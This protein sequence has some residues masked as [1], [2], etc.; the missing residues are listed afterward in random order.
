MLSLSTMGI[1]AA[2]FLAA[3]A[4]TQ[5]AS[6]QSVTGN[7]SSTGV[8]YGTNVPG[9]GA[10]ATQTVN[11]A[12]GDSSYS[13]TPNGPDANGS[14]LDAAYGTV[15]NGYLYL[16]FA[17]NFENN[18]NPVNIFIDD[19]RAGGQNTLNAPG[20]AGNMTTMNGSV[21]SPGFNA[22][23]AFEINDYQGTAYIDQFNLLPSG[24]G[25]FVGSVPLSAGVGASQSVN[26]S[27][28]KLGLNNSNT[29]GVTGD[30]TG[31]AA[32]AAN[33]QAVS[34]GM[35]L[36]VPLSLLGN[37]TGNIKVMADINGGGDSYLSNQFLPGLTPAPQGNVGA[38]GGAFSGASSGQFNLS[39]LSNFWFTVQ[40]VVVPDGIWLP[41]GDGSWDGSTT[42]NWSN[43]HIPNAAGASA[44]FSS[45]TA[46]A[47]VT[48][49]GNRTVGSMTIDDSNSYTFTPGAS[50]QLTLDN[51]GSA[52]TASITDV[53]G[54][55]TISVPLSLTS[56]V[57]IN[58]LSNGSNLT[59]SGNIT[60]AGAVSISSLGH[61]GILNSD[62]DVILS[63]NNNYLG[64]TTVN[65]GTLKLGSSTALP[66]NTSL[67]LVSSDAPAGAL[68]LNGFN[69][70]I[71]SIAGGNGGGGGAG[72]TQILNSSATAGTATLTY[73]GSNLSPNTF[74]GN[75]KDS[76]GT[77]GNA[78]HL[79]IASGSL[80]VTGN[81][82]YG[83]DTSIS[84]GATLTLAS[85]SQF[86]T[87]GGTALPVGGNVANN[88]SLVVNDNIQAG[89]ISGSGTTTVGSGMS[90]TTVSLN[91]AGGLVNN[92]TVTVNGNGTVGPI[93]GVGTLNVNGA[94]QLATSSGLSQMASLSVSGSGTFDI[95]NNHVVINYADG[96]D[97]ITAIASL[98]ST[99]YA[100]GSWSGTGGI[101]STAAQS[102]PAYSV[103]YADSADP[104]NPAALASGTLEIAFTLLGDANLDKAV[105]G[106]D[107]GILAANFNKGITGWDKGDFNYDNA[108]N[109]VDFGALAA[110]FN[111]GASA[112]DTAALIAFAE[113]NGLMADVPEPVS[114]GLLAVGAAGLLARRRRA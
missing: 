101:I 55:H 18:G 23:H 3:M 89:N 114:M 38:A 81:N 45:A 16:F 41:A 104:G 5:A 91:Q 22:T 56:N 88:G 27:G 58:V 13:G 65:K 31:S 46:T 4:G 44:S 42:T 75:I 12:F 79:T 49:V 100:G 64:G 99:G 110:N 73:S 53:S 80:T 14:E 105:N 87:P 103:G 95:N 33:A 47:T 48:V 83:G 93:S 60:G 6:A 43:G 98:L 8:G 61:N 69:A 24:T 111:K 34:T 10:L 76:S 11:T 72:T 52:A 1:S 77:G 71:S 28:I 19:G 63:G 108:V 9:T 66:A 50:G 97:P 35:E 54:N 109:G 26:G 96:P 70:S 39:S 82:T 37:P 59:V 113:A 107:F 94:L 78:T 90:L 85:L 92:G 25:S 51:G 29:A 106:V 36:G 40:Q 2:A 62:S 57:A 30:G 74:G 15:S 21:F 112:A 86:M 17:G 102:L 20:G 32:T 67:I 7:L 68:D 84:S